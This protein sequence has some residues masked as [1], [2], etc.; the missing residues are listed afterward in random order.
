MARQQIELES[1]SNT[2]KQW[3]LLNWEAH[4]V[5]KGGVRN[6]NLYE[7]YLKTLLQPTLWTV[8]C[9]RL[10]KMQQQYISTLIR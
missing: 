8:S 10:L 7:A 4:E 3:F 5:Y 6:V 2:L 9:C 1:C